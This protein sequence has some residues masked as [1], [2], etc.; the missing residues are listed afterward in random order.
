MYRSDVT[1]LC[2]TSDVY[3]VRR[4]SGASEM[5]HY[6]KELVAQSEGLSLV[7]ETAPSDCPVTSTSMLWYLGVPSPIRMS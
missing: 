6:V 2:D 7:E 4:A 5:A 3:F 1:Y